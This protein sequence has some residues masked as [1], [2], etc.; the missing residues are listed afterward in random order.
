ML[1]KSCILSTSGSVLVS[2]ALLTHRD[3]DSD[4]AIYADAIQALI[5]HQST[6]DKSHHKVT[7]M[8]S[9]Y[10]FITTPNSQYV[11]LHTDPPLINISPTQRYLT[12]QPPMAFLYQDIV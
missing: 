1:A 5:R 12:V 8:S 3:E 7:L 10:T 4:A 6:I 2:D 11:T 9:E